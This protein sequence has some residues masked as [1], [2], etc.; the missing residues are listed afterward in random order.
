MAIVLN[1]PNKS[2]SKLHFEKSKT[3]P[4]RKSRLP[5]PYIGFTNLG[6]LFGSSH[7]SPTGSAS[8]SNCCIK[9]IEIHTSPF[10]SPGSFG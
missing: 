9:E 2:K 6:F 3:L 5:L 8:A 10:C 1:A 4:L 7:D